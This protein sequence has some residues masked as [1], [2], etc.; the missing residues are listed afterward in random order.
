MGN[1]I[2]LREIAALTGCP[3]ML[4]VRTAWLYGQDGNNFVKTIMRLVWEK[5]FLEVVEDQR[6]CPTNA[7]DLPLPRKIY[8]RVTYEESVT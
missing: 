2:T 3:N 7:D 4:V 5:P 1:P 8:L 6:G